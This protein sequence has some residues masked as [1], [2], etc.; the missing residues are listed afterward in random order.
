VLTEVSRRRHV[1]LKLFI[2]P[3]SLGPRVDHELSMH[4]RISTATKWHPGRSSVRE[5]LDS[6]EVTEPDGCH[7]CLVHPPLWESVLT[8][9]RRNP[10]ERLPAVVLH[11]LFLALD[12]LHTECKIIHTDIK[13]DNIMFGI[14][15][16]TVFTAFEEQVLAE[17]SPRKLVKG[18][19]AIY[20]SRELRMPKEWGAPVLC[21][22]E[23]AMLGDVEHCE[24]VQP[25]V[26]RAPEVILEILWSYEIDIWNVGCMVSTENGNGLVQEL[27]K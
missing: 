24:D 20:V 27:T 22:F 7:H 16:D 14:E 3:E 19:R 15:D 21:D 18:D 23:S 5:L 17:P 13:A 26:Y 4:H 9:L 10:V 2:H 12:Y 8:F 6:F 1:T 25:D 11:R